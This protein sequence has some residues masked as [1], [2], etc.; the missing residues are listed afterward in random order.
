[1]RSAWFAQ[2]ISALD[3]DERRALVAVTPALRKLADS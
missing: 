2:Q 1:M 3:D